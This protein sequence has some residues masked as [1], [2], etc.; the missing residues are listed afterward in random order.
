VERPG[1]DMVIEYLERLLEI[2]LDLMLGHKCCKRTFHVHPKSYGA[3]NSCHSWL[4]S[5]WRLGNQELLSLEGFKEKCFRLCKIVHF[6]TRK[7]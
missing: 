5:C 2:W 7:Q 4:Q 3:G 1:E 6:Q